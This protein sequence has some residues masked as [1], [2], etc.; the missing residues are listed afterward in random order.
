MI[1]EKK[2]R[3]KKIVAR[4]FLLVLP[5]ILIGG[6]VLW[7]LNFYYG[8]LESQWVQE[9]IFLG[10]GI[11]T[12]CLLFSFRFR[13]ISAFLPLLLLLFVA[14]KVVNHL[15][16]GE[17]SAFFAITKFYIFSFLF[18]IGWLVGWGFA[19]LRWF[20]TVIS[21]LLMVMQI[22]VVSTTIDIT[23][24]K[25]IIAFA[26]VLLFA[27]YIIYTAELVRNMNDDEPNFIW[28]LVKKLLAFG[29]VA[30]ILMLI[31][32]S[33]YKKD[34]QA[35][36]KKYGGGRNE[37]QAPNQES[38]TRE[39]KDGSISNKKEMG[40]SGGRK[41]SNRLVFIARLD[42]FFPGTDIPNPLYF[43]YDY[44]TKFDTTTQT[45]ET[46]SLMPYN[47][48]FQPDPSKI[49]LYFTDVDSA[50]LKNGQGFL[51]RRV[52]STE[53]YKA[54]LS[55][56]EFLA[57][58]TAFFCQ[59]IA[60]DKE[61]RQQFKSAYRAKMLVSDLNS[62]YFVYNPAG[63]KAL[64]DFQKQRFDILRRVK[65]WNGVD[66]NFLTYYTYVPRGEDFDSI[67]ALAQEITRGDTTPI[68]KIISIRNY[69]LSTDE[70]GQP[71]FQYTDNPGVPG[72]PSVNKLDYFLFEN[73]K[74]YCA[75]FAGAT[76]FLLRSLGI[77]TRV[78]TGFL[79]MDR[80]TK[81]KGW[82]WFYE[83]QAHAWT[84]V[85][86]PGYGWLDFDTTIPSTEQQQAPAPDGTPPIT[87]QTALFVSNGK[88]TMVDTLA[89]R[90]DMAVTDMIYHDKTFHIQKPEI[91][92]MDVSLATISKDSGQVT[93]SELKAGNEITALSFSD[94]FK[95]LN[96]KD[97]NN[98]K[99]ILKKIPTPV[100]IDE[101]KIIETSKEKSQPEKIV[102]KPP[103]TIRQM[104]WLAGTILLGVVLMLLCTP[105][106]IFQWLNLCAK[107]TVS[108][109]RKAYWSY[110]AAMFYMN[111]SGRS[112]GNESPAEFA[113]DKVD[114]EFNTSF[115]G[116][117]QSYLKSK[118]S[119][120]SL[121]NA[122]T[123]IL[124]HFYLP[125][126]KTVRRQ[127]PYR[128]RFS[129]FLNFYRTF[130]FFSKSKT[131]QNGNSEY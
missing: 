17:F 1:I 21:V 69:F 83:H 36:E 46:D 29:S 79:T 98:Y 52:I 74:G 107:N 96:I 38:L 13:F 41:T 7:H 27:F 81:N 25:L 67:R 125:F 40:L 14:G 22:V 5:A 117:M 118:Y 78:A 131:Q 50:V 123:E 49:P 73:R 82:Y 122:E 105:W 92:H 97:S 76:L 32:F 91:I 19:R 30:G 102:A 45:L 130:Y 20:P 51:D 103:M 68:D 113:K 23:A 39:N 93:L 88:V 124:K 54:A 75:Y 111:Q 65:G 66:T 12:G 110:M 95:N 53:V 4:L 44:Y 114:R 8:I 126:I 99:E 47:D 6:Y 106:L 77:P 116:F 62:A 101:I 16:T 11:T 90:V 48:L 31:I 42:N 56:K 129:N 10:A 128:K 115:Y 70:T 58:S 55:P 35:I 64:E 9:S 120:D 63:N 108:P 59:P 121:T 84:Q 112:R 89:K 2:Y 127:I 100:P 94:Q 87:V 71:L 104:L 109:K 80:S 57:P 28:F 3:A 61:Y 15:F 85:F 60:I 18:V 86:F 43:T 33:L 37:T 26:P 24:R 72:L 119:P 34:F